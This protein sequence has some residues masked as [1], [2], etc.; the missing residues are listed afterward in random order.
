MFVDGFQIDFYMAVAVA[1]KKHALHKITITAANFILPEFQPNSIIQ[2]GTRIWAN[3]TRKHSTAAGAKLQCSNCA[4]HFRPHY[5]GQMG[6][7]ATGRMDKRGQTSRA[8]R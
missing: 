6:S 4:T 1:A 2:I 8:H 3:E 7:S 5:R